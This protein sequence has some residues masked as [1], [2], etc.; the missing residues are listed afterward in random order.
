MMAH[1]E[2]YNPDQAYV[3][4]DITR[5]KMFIKTIEPEL[6]TARVDGMPLLT[7]E[8]KISNIPRTDMQHLDHDLH[9][10]LLYAKYGATEYSHRVILERDGHLSAT[11]SVSGFQAKLNN[12]EISVHKLKDETK[13]NKLKKLF[14]RD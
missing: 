2:Q 5:E 9:V 4:S 8:L 3:D 6:N 14:G 10:A 7:K 11:S 13:D 12:T 1:T